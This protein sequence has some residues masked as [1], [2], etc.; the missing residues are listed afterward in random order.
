MRKSV[1]LTIVVASMACDGLTSN[2]TGFPSLQ[3]PGVLVTSRVILNADSTLDMQVSAVMSNP[4][5]THFEVAQCLGLAIISDTGVTRVSHSIGCPASAP[6]VDLAHADTLMLTR[7]IPADSL[8][9]FVPGAYQVN[10]VIA[11]D[12]GSQY[13]AQPFTLRLPLAR[14]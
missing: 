9:R 8:A 11:S 4:W 3:L 12:N 5:S 2:G 1:L 10:V 7:L 13:G 14:P 6:T